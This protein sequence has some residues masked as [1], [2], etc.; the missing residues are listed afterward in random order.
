LILENNILN[1]NVCKK[2]LGLWQQK[3]Q[4]FFVADG[5]THL[6]LMLQF[7]LSKFCQSFLRDGEYSFTHT[8]L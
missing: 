3:E 1:I 4:E 2:K 8:Q 5:I 7:S 6:C